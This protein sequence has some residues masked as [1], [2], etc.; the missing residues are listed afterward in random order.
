LIPLD[1]AVTEVLGRCATLTARSFSVGDALGHVLAEDVRA[2]EPVPPFANSA[3]DGFAVRAADIAG[4]TAQNPAR[5][6]VIGTIA[7]GHAPDNSVG[8][9]E[10]LRIMTGALF[11]EGADTVAIVETSRA[12]GD[13]VLISAPASA[14]EHVRAAGDDIAEG[15]D[16]FAA[17]TVLGPGHVGVLCSVGREK[18]KAVPLP[19]VG[20][21]S[22]G[23]ELVEAGGALLPGQIRDSNRRTLTAL[24]SRDGFGTVD[25]GIAPDDESEIER[26]LTAAAANCDAILTSG[27][28]SMGDFDYVKAVLDRVA[29]MRW[30]QVAIRPAKPFA[31]GTLGEVPVF[32]LPGNP[33]SSMVSYELLARPGLRKLAGFDA[34]VLRREAV[35]GV[36]DDSWRGAADGRESFVRVVA[37]FGDDG[38]LRARGAGGQG[39]HQLHAMSLANA[40]A[41]IGPGVSVQ[42][43]DDVRLLLLGP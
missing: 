29:D 1:D 39:S 34:G 7:A 3:M 19:T 40:L 27:G 26:R 11:P 9:G 41:V 21:L 6:K 36:A 5:L 22:T 42:P 38:R 18:I 15:A 24:L 37:S 33:V 10:A 13:H 14:G 2:A 20:V 23:D 43:G 16:V 17:G 8:E 30:M 25:L 28:V 31:F 12:D 32:G 4:A 35:P